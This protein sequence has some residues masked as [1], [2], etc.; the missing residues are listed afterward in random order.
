MLWGWGPTLFF[1]MWKTSCPAPYVKR[2]FSPPPKDLGALTENQPT[3]DVWVYFWTLTCIPKTDLSTFVSVLPSF[4]YCR[5]AISFEIRKLW[6]LH[7]CSFSRLFWLFGTLYN[8][9]CGFSISFSFPQKWDW[10]FNGYCDEPVEQAEVYCHH[11]NIETS[12]LWARKRFPL[13]RSCSV[14]LNTVV[15]FS[16]LSLMPPWL[17]LF[18]TILLLLMLL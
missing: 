2:L 10:I 16:V 8:S 7:F 12:N 11:N 14:S 5:F 9:I 17:N 6:V 15:S 13:V 18:A 1:G 4:D 3:T